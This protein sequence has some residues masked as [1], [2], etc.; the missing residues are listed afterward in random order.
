[1]TSTPGRLVFGGDQAERAVF[2]KEL[3]VKVRACRSGQRWHTE[4]LDNILTLRALSQS[5]RL[6]GAIEILRR[7]RYTAEVRRAA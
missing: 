1:M 2:A 6:P 5:D 3:A 7:D 4:G